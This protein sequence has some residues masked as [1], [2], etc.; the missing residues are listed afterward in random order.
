MVFRVV[1]TKKTDWSLQKTVQ[2][3]YFFLAA[4][5]AYICQTF[6][7]RLPKR[8]ALAIQIPSSN[9]YTML[10][11]IRTTFF[12][13]ILLTQSMY[14]QNSPAC[15]FPPPPGAE[16]CFSTCVYCDLDGYT[17]INNGTPSTGQTICGA[18]AIHNDQWF[19]FNAG[20][21]SITFNL[22]ASNCQN[23]DGLQIALFGDCNDF[24]AI[25]CNPGA[26]G[27]AHTDL[28]LSYDDFNV[29]Q[30]YSLMIDGWTGEVCDF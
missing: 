9:F 8:A 1:L 14:A 29:W 20:S 28:S 2:K 21:C 18:I 30:T 24:D 13:W 11:A 22:F 26:P 27:S 19:G 16:D 23:G 7:C 17:G 5:G 4:S 15:P 6:R 25:A 10:N 3:L 12:L